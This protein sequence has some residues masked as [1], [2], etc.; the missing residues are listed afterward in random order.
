VSRFRERARRYGVD[1][2]AALGAAPVEVALGVGLAVF[3]SVALRSTDAGEEFARAAAGVALAFPLVFGLSV[4]RVRGV[5]SPAVRWIGTAAA[6]LLAAW[7]GWVRLDGGREAEVWRWAM[8]AAAAVLLLLL[9][10]ALPWRSRERGMVWAFAARLAA[11]TAGI[12]LYAGVLYALLAGAVAAVVS[13]FELRQPEHL[14][15]D[16]AGAVFF[17]LAPLILVG[18]IHRL[19]APPEPGVPAAVGLLGRWLYAPALVVYL[20]ILYAYGIKVAATGELPRNLLS[21]LVIAAGMIG[22]LGGYLLEPVHGS[23]EHRGLSMLVR[24][25]PIVLLP[26]LPL[27]MWAL[28]A[29]LGEYGWTEFRYLRIAVVLAIGLLAVLGTVRF[30]RGG[31]PLQAT[32]PAVL[33]AVLLIASVGPWGA[34]SV[35]KRDQTARLRAALAEADVDARRLPGDTMTVDST[36]YERIQD[37]ARYLAETHGIGA[38]QEVVPALPDTTRAVWAMGEVL[39]LKRACRPAERAV[40]TIDW[41]SGVPGLGGGTVWEVEAGRHRSRAPAGVRLRIAGERLVADGEG[42]R[43]EG[44]LAAL[45]G[46]FGAAEQC[47]VR[48]VSAGRFRGGEALVVL[49]GADGLVRAQLIV[50]RIGAEGGAPVEVRGLLVLTP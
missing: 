40:A 50:T 38:L 36:A 10:P 19:V 17:A 31:A 41:R 26:L 28:G 24:V 25:V 2:R 22:L 48:P 1:A 23:G 49:R 27:A 35:S 33:A 45:A 34:T 5:V 43:A 42:W 9:A 3:L 8:L 30:F 12:A 14:Y 15:G 13:L 39:G 37:G 21:P 7:I 4:L 6:L 16:L 11:R 18:G 32:V 47:G 20:V 46:S 29:R 44:S